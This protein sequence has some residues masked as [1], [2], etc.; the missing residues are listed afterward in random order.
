MHLAD[1]LD[2]LPQTQPEPY[3]STFS[4]LST[5][6]LTLRYKLLWQNADVDPNQVSGEDGSSPAIEFI[7]ACRKEQFVP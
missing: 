3:D 7:L 2:N 5:E 6:Y 4:V 1:A